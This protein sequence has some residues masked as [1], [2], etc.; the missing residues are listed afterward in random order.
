MKTIG[1]GRLCNM[2]IVTANNYYYQRGGSERVLF[3]EECVLRQHG[4]RVLPFS[5]QDDR[6]EPAATDTYFVPPRRLGEGTV[7]QRLASVTAVFHNCRAARSFAALVDSCRPDIVHAH[8]IYGTLSTALISEAAKRGIPVVM[9]AHDTKVVCATYRCLD[10]ETVCEACQGKHFYRCAVRSCH[11]QGRGASMVF[12]AEAYYN[13]V[14]GRYGTVKCVIAPSLFLK[15]LLVRN[16]VS[17]DRIQHIPNAV[18]VNRFTP[19][20]GVGEYVLYAGRLS[21]EKGILT[22]L[23]AINGSGVPLRIVGEGPMRGIAERLASTL[24]LQNVRFEG[25]RSGEEL[26]KLFKNAAF[27]VLPSEWYENA[28]ISALEAFAYAK[29][30]LGSRIG[31]IPEL[32]RPGETGD[33]FE[34][35]SVEDLRAKLQRM[36]SNKTGLLKMGRSARRTVEENYSMDLH[37]SRLLRLYEQLSS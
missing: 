8:N 12:A 29:P 19:N 31:G 7:I 27:V 34:P 17:A 10:H 26:G 2:L 25:Y 33:L 23:K 22:L 35:K 14:L 30:V 20:G 36:W 3:D 18:D 28:P 32:V 9:T 5:T 1:E 4:H 21:S 24:R 13:R 37:Y 6:N 16:G 15:T 11:P